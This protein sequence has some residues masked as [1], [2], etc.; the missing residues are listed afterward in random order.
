MSLLSPVTLVGFGEVGQILAEDLLA[1]GA[2]VVAWDIQFPD[3]DSAPA[4]ALSRLQVRAAASAP[5]AVRGASLV[6]S[7]VTAAQDQE[8]AKAVAPGLPAGAFYLDLN[9]C[10]PGQKRASAQLIEGAGG[11]YVEAAVMSP[12][13]PKRLAA[14][15]LLGGPHADAFVGAAKGLGFS[16]AD[17]FS[18]EVGQAAAAKLCRSV[19]IKGIEALLGESLLAARRYGVEQTVL[20]SLSD[21]LPIPDWRGTARYMISRTLEHGT[22]RAEEMREAARTVAEAG[23]EPLMSLATAAR[24]DWAAA[25]R[26]ALG[27]ADLEGLLDAVNREGTRP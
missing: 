12:F 23:V 9:S 17:V 11:R 8:A 7:A 26:A 14:P 16:A 22:R 2:E 20:D 21:L 18:P 24:Q 5:E 27:E 15:M 10:S 1:A 13:P 6:I 19:V 3:P 4:R 25:F